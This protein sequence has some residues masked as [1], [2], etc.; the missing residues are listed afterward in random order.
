V[1]SFLPVACRSEDRQRIEVSRFFETDRL[2]DFHGWTMTEE[3]RQDISQLTDA[4]PSW[5][6]VV[7]LLLFVASGLYSLFLARAVVLW[8]SVWLAAVRLVLFLFVIYLLY[9]L[10]LAVERIA[11]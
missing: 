3:V 1:L 6:A 5:V 11:D 4:V 2:D 8:V 9:R 10:V 7:V